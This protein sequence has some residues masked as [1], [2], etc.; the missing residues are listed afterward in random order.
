MT[1]DERLQKLRNALMDIVGETSIE[2]MIKI[3]EII[4]PDAWKTKAI[5]VLIEELKIV[6]DTQFE[7]G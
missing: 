4:G 1:K 2:G 5:D 6:E 7:R 3:K